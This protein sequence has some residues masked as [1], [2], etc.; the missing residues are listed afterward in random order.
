M[1]VNKELF[2]E[3]ADAIENEPRMYEQACWGTLENEC[4]TPGCIAGWACYLQEQK[5]SSQPIVEGFKN[6]RALKHL[7]DYDSETPVPIVLFDPW[8]PIRWFRLAEVELDDCWEIDEELKPKAKQAAAV[9][10]A[11][12]EGKIPERELTSVVDIEDYE[13]C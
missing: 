2:N 10:R 4:R 8:W 1:T 5:D 12:A 9:C 11:I 13:V 3:I 6:T 7:F